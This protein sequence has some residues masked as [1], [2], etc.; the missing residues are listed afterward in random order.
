MFNTLTRMGASGAGG[1]YE[2]ERSVRFNN[3]TDDSRF[4]WTPSGAG[5]TKIF[6]FSCWVKRAFFGNSSQYLIQVNHSSYQDY[7]MF[8]SSERLVLKCR[9]SNLLYTTRRFRDASAWYHILVNTNTDNGTAGDRHQIW[10]NG[11]RETEF[12]VNNNLNGLTIAMNT[13]SDHHI[14]G[15]GSNG[16]GGYMAEVHLIDGQQI[17]ASNFGE[18][19]ADTGE[20]I[21]KEYEGSYGTNGFYLDFADNSGVTSTTLGKDSSGNS[22]NFTP[23]NLSVS[24]GVG[25]DSSED[26][27]TNNFPTFNPLLNRTSYAAELTNGNLDCH[28]P[29]G[30]YYQHSTGT[31][32]VKSG[33]W[34]WEV[35]VEDSGTAGD[36]TKCRIGIAEPYAPWTSQ[37][38]VYRWRTYMRDGQKVV[39]NQD[40]NTTSAYGASY[41]DGDVIGVALDLD[42]GTLIM[43]KNGTSQGTLDSTVTSAIGDYGWVAHVSGYASP[44]FNINFGQ[45]A[46]AHTPPTG[47]K[48]LCTANLSE[49]TIKDPAEH[50]KAKIYNGTGSTQTITTG[51]DADLVWVKRRDADGYHI[52]SNTVS[53]HSNYLVTNTSD[54]E[55]VG[56]GSQLINGFSSTGFQVGTE[57]AVNNS[58]G[59]YVSW[60]WKESATAGFDIVSYTGTGSARTVSHNLG[61]APDMMIIKN[62]DASE[63]WIVYHA[64]IASDAETDYILLNSTDAAGDDTW[65]NDTA[66]TSS[67][68]EYSGGGGTFN[69]NG[70]DYFAFLFSSVE[71]FSKFGKY[72]GNGNSDG[73]FIYLG[74]KPAY[75]MYRRTGDDSWIQ[76][77]IVAKPRSDQSVKE[78]YPNNQN[79]Q[80]TNTNR[81]MAYTANG[82]KILGSE[83]SIN[84]SGDTF[85]YRAFAESP[86]KYTNA[87]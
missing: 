21:P 6:T 55:S 4:E 67:Q 53:G 86:F 52:L 20:W 83:A 8:D 51:V 12:D 26:S 63:N 36:D 25:D 69:D 9:D 23:Q 3:N 5:N 59:T 47:Y 34:Y 44:N 27:P 73:P 35:T 76:S 56:G 68:W 81:K 42:N 72:V 87:E 71:G 29:N 60:S 45:R 78:L 17:D 62:R 37:E 70:E 10:I 77:D 2:I 31:M 65:L 1:A 58:S 24:A 75:F 79:S 39:G 16:F 11:V 61:V 82:I 49:P 54:A 80:N 85:I 46:F 18:E 43:Y 41:T 14:G 57:S 19:D 33:K 7:I 30:S 48:K 40:S 22:N 74:F 32:A 15:N 66:P 28:L 50:F 38:P 64:G 84:T 13:A